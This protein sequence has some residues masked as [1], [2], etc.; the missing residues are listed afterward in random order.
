MEV[1]E[2]IGKGAI[3]I[4]AAVEGKWHR[5][6][7]ENVWYVPKIQK[8]LFSV[9]TAQDKNPK[10]RFISTVE[11]CKLKIGQDVKLVGV[12]DRFGGLFK[13]RMR[14]TKPNSPAEV[15]MI[16]KENLL[17][18]YHER[19]GHQNKRHVKAI[20][21]KELQMN[22]SLNT[23]LCKG[24]I[25]G[26]AHRLPFGTRKKAM[27]PGELVYTDVCGPFQNSTSGY[28]YFVL[29]RDDYTKF[30]IIYF[31]KEK[32]EVADKLKQ[33]LA[34]TKTTGHVI[35]ELLSDN[36][37]EFDNKQVKEI[38]QREGIIQRL[39]MPYTPQQNGCSERENRTVVET[40]RTIMHAYGNI[41]Q[42][43]LAEMINSASYILNR[44]GPSNIS[45]KSPYELWYSK[46]PGIKHLRIIGST[47][48]AH[49]P[50][51]R[52]KKMDRKAVKGILLGYDHNEGYRILNEENKLIR[53]LD[54]IFKEKTLIQKK[55][56][57]FPV[58][59]DL[60][61]QELQDSELQTE[62]QVEVDTQSI[63]EEEE[64]EEETQ[65]DI[66][67]TGEPENNLQ[68]NIETIGRQLLDRST[69][70][71]PEK[72]KDYIAYVST[73]FREPETYIEAIKSDQQ[74]ERKEAMDR[75]I[76]ALQENQTWT[77]EDLPS[78]K[79][80]IP[81]KWVYRIKTNADGSIDKFKARLVIKGFS[82]QK[83]VDFDQTFNPIARSFTIR[84]LLSVAANENMKLVQIDVSTAFLYGNLKETILMK[85][86]EG[87]SAIQA[88]YVA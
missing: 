24:C 74:D 77:L 13:L 21:D 72:F 10:S 36:G 62:E 60:P 51:Q 4:E 70:K 9:L 27:K 15:N 38:L 85:Q 65:E 14:C 42:N 16:N 5:L 33:F 6:T 54:V 39:I 53:S 2:A 78:G 88:K 49:I 61:D 18:L 40:A 7:L 37:G 67:L 68:K 35:K 20:I 58:N 26:K 63:E 47:C 3:D 71:R 50:K 76:K 1:I 81:C 75:E 79:R 46:K 66:E 22:V 19:F 32:S 83:G 56:V 69:I 29:F 34:E 59:A 48:Y 43:L 28:R 25:Y 44:T 31:I 73:D 30:R 17:Q 87:Y 12:L 64:S 57:G 84:T 23:E 45:G 8:N 11:V 41:T 55:E 80:A 86:P 52:R 82:Q